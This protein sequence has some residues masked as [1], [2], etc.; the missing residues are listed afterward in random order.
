[1]KWVWETT[2][3]W[4][5]RG[6]QTSVLRCSLSIS[7][8]VILE[9][10]LLVATLQHYFKTWRL[11][12]WGDGSA[13]KHVLFFQRTQVP[14]PAPKTRDPNCLH[15][16][17]QGVWC[18]FELLWAPSHTHKEMGTC[19]HINFTGIKNQVRIVCTHRPAFKSLKQEQHLQ[20]LLFGF[21]ESTDLNK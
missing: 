21:N 10:Q 18:H 12:G 17:L 14:F 7:Y 9:K 3:L 15:L 8:S 16:Q 4:S 20:R 1:M 11:R 2:E 13:V 19:T 6:Q 5:S